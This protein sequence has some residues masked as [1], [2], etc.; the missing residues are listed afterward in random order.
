MSLEIPDTAAIVCADNTGRPVKI[1]NWRDLE[2]E[3]EL[4]PP[5]VWL[6]TPPGYT[7]SAPPAEPYLTG[8]ASLPDIKETGEDHE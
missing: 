3:A 8:P 4:P 6:D 5:K 1:S 7:H 2:R